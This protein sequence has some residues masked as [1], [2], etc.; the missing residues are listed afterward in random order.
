MLQQEQENSE[1]GDNSSTVP[2]LLN[3]LQKCMW[4]TCK[5]Q[6]SS[7]LNIPSQIE[8]THRIEFDNLEKLFYN[9]QHSECRSNFMANVN[10]YTKRMKTISPQIMKRVRT[11]KIIC[12]II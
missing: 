11:T 1:G 9:E 6:I 10:I 12:L 7:E 5:T 8:I 3:V 2:E 4:R